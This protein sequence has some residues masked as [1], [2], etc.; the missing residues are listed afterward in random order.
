MTALEQS[1]NDM[2]SYHIG[3]NDDY[4]GLASELTIYVSNHVDDAGVLAREMSDDLADCIAMD[5][6]EL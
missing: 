1:I 2:I 4:Q 3:R 6:D 5:G